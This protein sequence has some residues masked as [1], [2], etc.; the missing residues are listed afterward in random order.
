MDIDSSEVSSQL[1]RYLSSDILKTNKLWYMKTGQDFA[2]GY[3][4]DDI[5]Q[6]NQRGLTS[7]SSR[8]R[9]ATATP[10]SLRRAWAGRAP[11]L[12]RPRQAPARGPP[13]AT[14]TAK[15]TK[16]RTNS[17][18]TPSMQAI[19]QSKQLPTPTARKS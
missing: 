14:K 3:K 19:L 4:L 16:Q 5:V 12:P 6:G 8:L 11:S 9:P 10:R 13:T 17:G 2:F 18:A 7:T 1:F 15:Y